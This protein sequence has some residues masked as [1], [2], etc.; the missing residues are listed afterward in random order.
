[1]R[2]CCIQKFPLSCYQP[3]AGNPTTELSK[4]LSYV[5]SFTFGLFFL[6][7]L[8][9]KSLFVLYL[10]ENVKK[11]FTKKNNLRIVGLYCP[12]FARGPLGL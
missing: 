7:C 5:S 2:I 4:L 6:N 8:N 10:I 9:A 3:M 11:Q 1:M 12:I